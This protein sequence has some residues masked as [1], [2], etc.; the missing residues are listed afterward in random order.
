MATWWLVLG[1]KK[2]ASFELNQVLQWKQASGRVCMDCGETDAVECFELQPQTLNVFIFPCCPFPFLYSDCFYMVTRRVDLQ[3]PSSP[4]WRTLCCWFLTLPSAPRLRLL[5]PPDLKDFLWFPIRARPILEIWGLMLINRPIFY[6]LKSISDH[7]GLN[8][9]IWGLLL[10]MCPTESGEKKNRWQTTITNTSQTKN[11]IPG[12]HMASSAE[13]D[14]Q[15]VRPDS[16][17]QE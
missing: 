9:T 7:D 4:I 10:F 14:L 13:I 1:G 3:N 6:Y 5:I 11:N 16:A 17:K 8:L 15:K 2:R 12:S